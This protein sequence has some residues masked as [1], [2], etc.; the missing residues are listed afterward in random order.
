MAFLAPLFLLGLLAAAIPIAIHLIRKEKPPKVHFSTLRFFRKTSR[1]QFLFQR[2]QQLLLLLLRAAV[3][4]LLAFAFARPFINE[5]LSGWA[6]IAPRSVVMVIDNSMSMRFDDYADRAQ[7]KAKDVLAE[8][9]PGDEAGIIVFGDTTSTVRGLTTDFESLSGVIENIGSDSYA[10]TRFFPALRLADEMLD[11]GRFEEKEVYLISDFYANGMTDFD[12][13]WKL[14]PGVALVT[15]NVRREDSTNLVVTGVKAPTFIRSGTDQDEIFVRV[16]SMGA[17]HSNN[18]ELVVSVDDV[19][20]LS[21]TINLQDQSETV[22]NFP[23]AFEGEGSHIGKI[24]IIDEGFELDNDFYFSVDVLPKINVLVVNGEASNNW[25]DDEG[26]WFRLAVNSD[27]K[28]P[29][30]VTAVNSSGVNNRQ[31][32]RADVVVLLNAGNLSNTQSRALV[33]Y[34]EAGGSVLFAP[35]DRVSAREFNTQFSSVSP[36]TLISADTFRGNDYLL[37]ADI[38]ARHPILRPL[39]IDWGVRFE[40]HWSMKADEAAE[41]LMRFDNGAPALVERQIGEGR[42]LLFASALD[43]EWNNLPL[44]NMYLPFIHEMLKHLA[45]TEEKKPS[46]VVGEKIPLSDGL[47]TNTR[48]IDPQGNEIAQQEG[49]SHLNLNRPGVYTRVQTNEQ[50]SEDRYFYAVNTPVEESNFSGIAPADILDEV[51]NPETKPT[52][53]AEVR[54]QLLK[55][56]LEKPQR[57]WWWLLMLVACLL[58]AESFVANRTHR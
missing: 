5:S 6:D 12:N 54:S 51:L 41:V 33:S 34:V 25:F 19:E 28:S 26:H 9:R 17:V 14:R 44:Q 11:E 49:D 1:K 7:Q 15:E 40:G 13:D 2:I 38:E 3:L 53:S 52:Q 57:L 42:T 55:A 16:R 8:L 36:A 39:E 24:S 48:L 10:T 27:K 46:Y 21:K 37:I 47:R 50:G 32:Q 29:F 20:Q 31:L 58:V 30:A 43:M 56:E 18:A 22:V 35:G 4:S 23:V 45:H